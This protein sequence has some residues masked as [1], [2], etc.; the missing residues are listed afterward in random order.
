M[1]SPRG[2]RGNLK[3]SGCIS[4]AGVVVTDTW[5][6]RA[7]GSAHRIC[8]C[9]CRR[10]ELS[11]QVCSEHGNHGTCQPF[12][13]GSCWLCDKNES[14]FLCR[15]IMKMAWRY[16]T[17]KL[18]RFGREGEGRHPWKLILRTKLTAF[19]HCCFLLGWKAEGL[20]QPQH[21]AI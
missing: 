15:D 1:Q 4:I 7:L 6:E 20:L 19:C 10:E 9:A 14:C 18:G 2:G 21:T 17:F 12:T 8:P 13:L 16:C 3:P 11:A 5:P